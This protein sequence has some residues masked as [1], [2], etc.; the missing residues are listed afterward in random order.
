MAGSGLG[1]AKYKFE[2]IHDTVA[3]LE[4]IAAPLVVEITGKSHASRRATGSPS[5]SPRAAAPPA[6]SASPPGGAAVSLAPSLG[7]ASSSAAVAV[8][9]IADRVKFETS[10]CF[11]ALRFLD[12]SLLRSV[13][14]EPEWAHRASSV[15]FKQGQYVGL[16]RRDSEVVPQVGPRRRPEVCA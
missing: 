1:R 2:K 6:P 5:S 13:Y 3:Q 11:D 9:I 14:S 16:S 15:D 7:S 12:D 8:P 10:P 4:Q